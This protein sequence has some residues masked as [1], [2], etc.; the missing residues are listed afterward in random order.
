MSQKVT[1]HVLGDVICPYSFIGKR[2]V[3]SALR[4][5][6]KENIFVDVTWMPFLL[7]R[8]LTKSG[9]DKRAYYLEKFNREP[10]EALK[11]P[12]SLGEKCD[13]PITFR[14]DGIVG[15]SLDAHRLSLW[16]FDKNGAQGQ[17][18]LLEQFFSSH[19]TDGRNI[20]DDQTLLESV[21]KARLPVVDAEKILR[22]TDYG[23][24]VERQ[25]RSRLTT[26]RT[27]SKLTQLLINIFLKT[28]GA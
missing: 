9:V 19:F 13:P 20:G 2:N 8:N 22:G 5:L 7:S 15:S 26:G 21:D 25:S 1:L 23:D 27:F 28:F 4:Q 24:E 17:S 11:R 14:Y 16:A 3:E 12:A 18:D 10:E 6:A